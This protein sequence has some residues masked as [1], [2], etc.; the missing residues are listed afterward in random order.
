MSTG[1]IELIT[2]LPFWKKMVNSKPPKYPSRRNPLQKLD[3]VL[4][5]GHEYMRGDV[6]MVYNFQEYPHIQSAY[7]GSIKVGFR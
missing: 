7:C 5:S 6:D 4:G 1:G 2:I 3:A